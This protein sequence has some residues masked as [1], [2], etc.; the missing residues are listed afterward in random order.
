MKIGL[1][2]PYNIYRGGGVQ[3][4]VKALQT[5]L[6]ARGHEV[7]IITPSPRI[8]TNNHLENILF[9]GTGTD[10]KSM[11][12]TTS[13]VSVSINTDQ[14][15][16]ML[17]VHKFDILHFHEPWV[18]IVSRQIL[19]RSQSINVATFHAKLPETVMTRTIE[20]VIT[21]Y[22]RS[23][24][25]YF[26]SFTAVSAAASEY[27][28]SIS[29][30]PIKII[31]NGIDLE[32]Y[33]PIKAHKNSR[34]VLYI[35]RLEKRKG[36]KFL[37]KAWKNASKLN[38]QTELIIAG[39]GSEKAKLISYV[40][41]NKIPRVRFVGFINDSEKKKLL[42]NATVFCS[43]ARYGE[44]FGIVLLE[45][46]AC[47]IPIIAGDNPGYSSVLNE[48]GKM[49]LIDPRDTKEFERRLSIFL[50][51]PELRV[52]WRNWALKYVQQ[53]SYKHIVDQYESLY[54]TLLRSK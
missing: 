47:G 44:S 33:T 50:Q 21:P 49:A 4:C 28:E 35:G 22:T 52:L 30:V 38:L 29:N 26:N 11:F 5:E 17:A 16:E 20:K 9:L 41:I 24:L 25:K 42:K 37:L 46:L 14:L 23:V 8:K 7:Y 19:T 53:F 10:V 1:I 36:V 40:K 2:C 39:D 18:P 31:H 32:S 45:A 43:P 6:I 13:Q 3:E 12:H 51:D 27:V 34:N 48:R 15:D 54:R